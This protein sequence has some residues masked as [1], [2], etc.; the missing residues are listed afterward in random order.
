MYDVLTKIKIQAR[1]RW[2]V[3]RHSSVDHLCTCVSGTDHAKDKFASEVPTSA[4]SA[5]WQTGFSLVITV[6]RYPLCL[7]VCGVFVD[8]TMQHVWV[9]EVSGS[10]TSSRGALACPYSRVHKPQNIC[11]SRNTFSHSLLKPCVLSQTETVNLWK[12]ATA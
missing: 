7:R 5:I 10:C 3:H 2:C 8:T 11:K 9:C 12:G 6:F 1:A 4:H